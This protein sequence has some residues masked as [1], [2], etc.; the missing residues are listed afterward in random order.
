MPKKNLGGFGGQSPPTA[1]N[2]AAAGRRPLPRNLPFARRP[3]WRRP[4]LA[5]ATDSGPC[6]VTPVLLHPPPSAPSASG[7]AAASV[8]A[9][10]RHRLEARHPFR[11][12]H[13]E[14]W[15]L[16]PAGPPAPAQK[17]T[18][19][20]CWNRTFKTCPNTEA[21]SAMPA[22][23]APPTQSGLLP[24]AGLRNRLAQLRALAERA[25]HGSWTHEVRFGGRPEADQ[26]KARRPPT[27]AQQA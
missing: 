13:A 25:H 27:L 21:D 12:S 4:A 11:L 2:A 14:R 24:R 9:P 1:N 7:P 8:P 15:S 6:A 16:I 20:T 19:K 5:G 26:T 3:G 22:P 23:D 17:R 18:F 10:L